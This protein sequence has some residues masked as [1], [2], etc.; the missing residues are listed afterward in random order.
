MSLLTEE[1][2]SNLNSSNVSEISSTFQFLNDKDINKVI[3]ATLD[4]DSII[5]LLDEVF[6]FPLNFIEIKQKINYN[7]II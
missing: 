6:N 5:L 2:L 4:F 1:S 3:G 7:N